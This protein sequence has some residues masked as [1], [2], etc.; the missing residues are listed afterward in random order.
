MIFF[1]IFSIFF[2]FT[3][4]SSAYDETR[5]DIVPDGNDCLEC[6]TP[7]PYLGLAGGYSSI[8]IGDSDPAIF[9][10]TQVDMTNIPAKSERYGVILLTTEYGN[11]SEEGWTILSDPNSTSA[12]SNYV[13]RPHNDNSILQWQ[14]RN[15]PGDY[16]IKVV[17]MFSSQGNAH[18]KEM[19]VN[20]P[21]S[22]L[23]SNFPPKLS[24]PKAVLLSDGKTYDFE[25]TYT[26]M[27][28]DD[29]RN[30]TVNISGL[31]SFEMQPRSTGPLNV[32]GGVVYY[33]L[34]VLPQGRYS[35]HFSASD[36]VYSKCH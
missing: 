26:D 1:V 35:Y 27:E 28:F 2:A 32:S 23:Q 36:G 33:Y 3:F 10:K 15:S 25:V 22:K 19:D 7:N 20:V 12:R 29:P 34:T 21:I 4:T 18:S 17:V 5:V 6:H 16:T 13:E 8:S 31:G 30:I 24:K 9:I 14:L 11:L